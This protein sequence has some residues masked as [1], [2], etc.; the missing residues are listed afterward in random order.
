MNRLTAG[1]RIALSLHARQLD[2]TESTVCL[3]AMRIGDQCETRNDDQGRK[4][5][6][7]VALRT[8]RLSVAREGQ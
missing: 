7:D 3:S 5:L 2:Q 1:G 6:A 8:L 4:H